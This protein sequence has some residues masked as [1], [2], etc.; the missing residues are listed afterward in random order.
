MRGEREGGSY[1]HKAERLFRGCLFLF[2][3]VTGRYVSCTAFLRLRA[4]KNHDAKT[5]GYLV[6]K[7]GEILPALGDDPPLLENAMRTISKVEL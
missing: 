2:M 6:E 4:L 7:R 1:R 3:A 5:S